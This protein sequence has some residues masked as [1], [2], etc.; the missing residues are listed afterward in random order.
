MAT[1]HVTVAV[2]GTAASARARL[3]RAGFTVIR[4]ATKQAGGT[5]T[6]RD[7]NLRASAVIDRPRG[8]DK[9]ERR[10]YVRGYAEGCMRY[11]K[12]H[13][14]PTLGEDRDREALHRAVLD[15]EWDRHPVA[16]KAG[17]AELRKHRARV[18][19]YQGSRMAS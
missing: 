7:P 18:E 5:I 12:T 14:C 10:A 11:V 16:H 4:A 8:L 15:Y 19:A 3:E 17:M 2:E 9:H 1:I 13:G 6:P